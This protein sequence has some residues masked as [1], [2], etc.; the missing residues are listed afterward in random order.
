MRFVW[1]LVIGFVLLTKVAHAQQIIRVLLAQESSVELEVLSQLGVTVD[2]TH[3]EQIHSDSILK[4]H[5]QGR[6]WKLS[7]RSKKDSKKTA[8]TLLLT[9]STLRLSASEL[10]W[11]QQKIK[12]PITLFS[13]K[14]TISVVGHMLVDEYLK[15]VVPHEMPPLW[16]EE[17]L[18]A[19]VVASRS[20][21]LWKARTQ[22]QEPYDVQATVM[23]QVF[24]LPASNKQTLNADYRVEQ[25]ILETQNQVLVSPDQHVLKAYFHSDCG[26]ATETEKNIWGTALGG[27]SSAAD[28]ACQDRRENSWVSRWSHEK[29]SQVVQSQLFV[30]PHLELKDVVIRSRFKSQRVETMDLIFSKGILKRL[31]G[32]D[33]R[34]ILGYDNIKSTL[35]QLQKVAGH[36]VFQGKGHGHGVGLCQWG[37]RSMAKSG[38]T[39]QQILAHYYP[40]AKLIT[41]VSVQ[42]HSYTQE[43]STLSSENDP[44]FSKNES[45]KNTL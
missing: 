45:Q 4:I 25:A 32:E 36:W 40:Q 11:K 6:Q 1:S 16:P 19:Q 13:P 20:Y 43:E 31:R 35:F 30:P 18:K 29:L 34:R 8:K 7:V 5:R 26:G 17:T 22:I 28:R 10:I 21:A 15:G 37:A 38:K 44:A 27:A 33:V 9:G 24:R 41:P 23:D 3:S 39:Y 2:G 42:T 14:Q 12:F